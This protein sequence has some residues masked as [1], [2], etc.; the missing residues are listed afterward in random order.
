MKRIFSMRTVILS[1]ASFVLLINTGCAIPL[2][3]GGAAV[4][5]G[6]VVYFKGQLEE[7]IS[8]SSPALYNATVAALMSMTMPIITD[9]HDAMTAE[10]KSSFSDGKTVWISISAVTPASCA[11]KIRVGTFGDEHR[12]RII[13]E[14]IR[15]QLKPADTP[16]AAGLPEPQLPEQPVNDSS[17]ETP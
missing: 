16:P 14:E 9:Q 5:A 7:T 6:T 4:G 8:A 10:I 17:P 2:I 12:S 13:L 3:L 1:L 15:K 11:V